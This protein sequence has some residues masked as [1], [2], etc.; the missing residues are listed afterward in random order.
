[1]VN[2]MCKESNDTYT[3]IEAS[4]DTFEI[5]Q[6]YVKELIC[7]FIMTFIIA[8][9]CEIVSILVIRL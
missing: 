1:M 2:A 6:I 3:L 7:V 4:L 8:V 9:S 5:E